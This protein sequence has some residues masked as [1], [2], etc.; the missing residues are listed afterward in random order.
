M[1]FKN[2]KLHINNKIINVQDRD[3]IPKKF[4]LTKQKNNVTTAIKIKIKIKNKEKYSERTSKS[5]L[6]R[7]YDYNY[8]NLNNS[9]PSLLC[10]ALGC[11]RGL[12]SK[13]LIITMMILKQILINTN[14]DNLPIDEVSWKL[15][16]WNLMKKS[17]LK[18]TCCIIFCKVCLFDRKSNYKIIITRNDEISKDTQHNYDS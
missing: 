7:T 14:N 2:T 10:P 11:T 4:P 17:S 16:D 8:A 12:F 3:I 5:W 15:D 13:L 18:F 1:N 9:K 6:G